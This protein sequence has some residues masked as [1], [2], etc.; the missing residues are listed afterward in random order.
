MG[1]KPA[2][3]GTDRRQQILE[4]GLQVFAQQGFEPATTKEIAKR[5]EVNQGLI[6]FYFVNKADLF[7]T[8]LDQYTQEALAQLDFGPAKASTEL[9]ETTLPL[10]LERI[11]SVLNT[12]QCVNLLR[13]MDVAQM[14]Q[15]LKEGQQGVR[16]LGEHIMKGLKDYLD[17]QIARRTLAHIDTELV[18]HLM[19][20]M[21]IATILTRQNSYLAH[22]PP[23]TV[24][25][26][27][28]HI[29]V[30]GLLPQKQ[31]HHLAENVST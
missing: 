18:A 24:A 19:T 29:F 12:P 10:L 21:L 30:Q 28:A 8:V 6:Y 31:R 20:R 16:A 9:P 3:E 5:A 4:A 14:Q 7:L 13:I 17:I 15:P 27:I 1:R 22:I 23:H 2:L 26:T 11:L 25:Q